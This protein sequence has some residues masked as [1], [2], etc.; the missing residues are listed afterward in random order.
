MK[1]VTVESETTVMNVRIKAEK[2]NFFHHP[3]G[4]IK[5]AT[6]NCPATKLGLINGCDPPSFSKVSEADSPVMNQEGAVLRLLSPAL[7]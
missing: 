3:L 7:A 1:L 6:V 2:G 4:R 5:M